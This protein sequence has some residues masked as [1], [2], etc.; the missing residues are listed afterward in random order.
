MTM[1]IRAVLKNDYVKMRE[2]S[3]GCNPPSNVTSKIG[4][5]SLRVSLVGRNLFYLRTERLITWIRK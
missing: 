5:Q 4:V 3:R 2:M 1:N